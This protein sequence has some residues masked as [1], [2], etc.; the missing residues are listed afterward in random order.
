[1]FKREFATIGGA[2]RE[3]S[4]RS[5]WLIVARRGVDSRFGRDRM[6][7]ESLRVFRIIE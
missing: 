7:V 2:W 6:F 4:Y 5:I 3:E 1:M